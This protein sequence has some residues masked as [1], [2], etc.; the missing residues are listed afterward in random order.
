MNERFG[1]K[2]MHQ[3]KHFS[4]FV[5]YN[6]PSVGGKDWRKHCNFS[7]TAAKEVSLLKKKLCTTLLDKNCTHCTSTLQSQN[8]RVLRWCLIEKKGRFSNFQFVLLSPY[9]SFYSSL[10]ILW[11]QKCDG[12]TWVAILG[13]HFFIVK[14]SWF[15]GG[16]V[17]V[18]GL[19]ML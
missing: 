17:K 11:M 13:S 8:T 10:I 19:L 18:M 14:R 15:M 3:V 1:Y 9:Y 6:L 4:I 16:C 12:Y 2:K 7:V 5:L